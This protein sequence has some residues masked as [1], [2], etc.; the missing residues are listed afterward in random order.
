MYTFTVTALPAIKREKSVELGELIKITQSN[1]K[2]RQKKNACKK[3]KLRHIKLIKYSIRVLYFHVKL[4]I[5]YA[6]T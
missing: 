4:V 3:K 6:I 1:K 2:N 5:E